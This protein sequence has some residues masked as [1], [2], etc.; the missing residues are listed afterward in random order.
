MGFIKWRS[1]DNLYSVKPKLLEKANSIDKW[2]VTEKVDGANFSITADK[3]GIKLGKRSGFIGENENFFNILKHKHKLEPLIEVLS[4]HSKFYHNIT[5]YGEY[6]GKDVIRR[7]P[8]D[9]DGDFVFYCL[10]LTTEDGV[11]Q[12]T[13]YPFFKLY[14]TMHGLKS[15]MVP[16]LKITDS[17]EE[18]KNYPTNGESKLVGDSGKS[19]EGV[20]IYPLYESPVIGQDFLVFK[21]KSK[22]FSEKIEKKEHKIDNDLKNKFK[23]YCTESRMWSVFSKEG[24][25]KDRKDAG[26]YI[27]KFVEDAKVDF[28]KDNKELEKLSDKELK[29]MC[30]IGS[31]GFNLFNKC[32]VKGAV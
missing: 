27:S 13:P 15:F 23:D 11:V 22:D 29:E 7:I 12:Y 16:Q 17:F 20:V 2:V 30:N 21:N 4:L 10:M 31:L 5:I 6:F 8:Y 28:L 3:N 14:M 18:A 26:R 1:I 9:T 19:M 24:L 25:P 32:C